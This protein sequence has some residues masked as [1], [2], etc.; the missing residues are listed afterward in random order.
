MLDRLLIEF[1]HIIMAIP[2]P[3]LS[4][5]KAD[6]TDEHVQ[7]GEQLVANH[8]GGTDHSIFDEPQIKLGAANPNDSEVHS[9][10]ICTTSRFNA[11]SL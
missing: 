7:P 2:S 3:T 5:K 6:V 11:D 8:T 10:K 9:L 4:A 1:F